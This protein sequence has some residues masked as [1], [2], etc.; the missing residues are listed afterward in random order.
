MA[1]KATR[2]LHVL[3]SPYYGEWENAF[4]TI[5]R[6]Y[7]GVT[8]TAVV[9]RPRTELPGISFFKAVSEL[10]SRADE[11]VVQGEATIRFDRD[12]LLAVVCYSASADAMADRLDF[13]DGRRTNLPAPR[14]VFNC[15]R[16]DER[17]KAVH[18][19]YRNYCCGD[20]AGVCPPMLDVGRL[21]AMAGRSS[22]YTIGLFFD[23]VGADGSGSSSDSVYRTLRDCLLAIRGANDPVRV[24]MPDCETSRRLLQTIGSPD[25][26]GIVRYFSIEC[27]LK[28]YR[29]GFDWMYG[30][31]CDVV[32]YIPLPARGQFS[33]EF[34]FLAASAMA[35]GKAV[36]VFSA[37][38]GSGTDRLPAC[39]SFSKRNVSHLEFSSGG[40]LVRKIAWLRANNAE[41][42]MLSAAAQNVSCHF[43]KEAA[44]MSF[45]IAV[46]DAREA[47]E[48][49]ESTESTEAE[50]E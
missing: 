3:P 11:V 43:D 28:P 2:M 20:Y 4:N 31:I 38:P 32:A 19:S 33:D 40:D 29:I 44:L 13:R 14:V 47:V 1:E 39:F 45:R 25:V 24:V 9:A 16:Y 18:L 17:D 34:G 21:S 27:A 46:N 49:T 37:N 7:R 50:A 35:M 6:T 48:S 41:A 5:N 8:H 36:A 12:E 23:P 15:P 26:R 30:S 42:R 22:M 10:Q